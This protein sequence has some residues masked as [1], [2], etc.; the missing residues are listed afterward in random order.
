MKDE[1]EAFERYTC[2]KPPSNIDKV[3]FLREL[4]FG[5][6]IFTGNLRAVYKR[7]F[8]QS[9]PEEISNIIQRMF[10]RGLVKRNG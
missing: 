9:M 1:E 5:L 3:R 4:E 10:E 7:E 2:V 6:R 8:K